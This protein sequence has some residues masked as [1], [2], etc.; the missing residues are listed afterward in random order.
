MD[1]AKPPGANQYKKVDR[2]FN[3]TEPKNLS[4]MGVTKDQSGIRYL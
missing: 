4:E 3:A 1:M 2:S